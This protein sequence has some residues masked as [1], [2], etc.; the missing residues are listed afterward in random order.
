[1]GK[2]RTGSSPR[3]A[4]M[5]ALAGSAL[6]GPLRQRA[7]VTLFDATTLERGKRYAQ[8]GRI[9]LVGMDGDTLLTQCQGSSARPYAQHLGW[10]AH[11]QLHATCSCPVGYRCKHCL[12]ALWFL[13]ASLPEQAS[14]AVVADVLSPQLQQWLQRLPDSAQRRTGGENAR[15]HYQL[16]RPAKDGEPWSIALHKAQIRRDGSVVQVQPYQAL[17]QAITRLPRFLSPVDMRIARLSQ[18]MEALLEYSAHYTVR[19]DDRLWLK[20]KEGSELLALMLGT[21]HLFLDPDDSVQPLFGG[22]P[23]VAQF[24]WRPTEQAGLAP[25]WETGD[26][27]ALDIIS[28]LE[29]LWYLDPTSGQVGPVEH[30]LDPAIAT[31][32]SLAPAVPAAETALFGTLLQRMAPSLPAPPVPRQRL[33]EDVMPTA[34]LRLETVMTRIYDARRYRWQA[35]AR[36]VAT[37][38]F[39]YQGSSAWGRIGPQ[40]SV[41]RQLRGQEAVSIQRQPKAEQRLR[42][43]LTALG[44]DRLGKRDQPTPEHGEAYQ[45]PGDQAWI[46]FVHTG[47]DALRAAGWEIQSQP[48]FQ[49]DFSPVQGWQVNVETS[50]AG[51]AWFDLGLDIVVEG[52]Q[53]PLLPIVLALLRQ[54]PELLGLPDLPDTQ[55]LYVPVEGET[56]EHGRPLK[57]ALPYERIRPLLAMLV[58]F[59]SERDGTRLSLHRLDASQLDALEQLPWDW[60]GG[61]QLRDFGKRLRQSARSDVPVP[62]GLRTQLR[63]YQHDGLAWLQRLRELEVGGVLADDMGLGKTVQV[64]AHLLAEQQAGRRDRPSLIVM[65]TSLV[66]N[67]ED[68]AARFAPG[69]RVLTLHGPQRHQAFERLGEYDL[70][71]TTYALLPRDLETLRALPLHLLVLDEAQAIKN[72]ASKAAQAACQLQAR[73]RLCLSGTPLENHLGELWSLYHFL[74]PGWLG[75]RK[76]FARD[77]RT[78]IEQHGSATRLAHLNARL[79]PFLLRRNKQQVATQLP[80]KTQMVHWVELSPD[81]RDTYESVRTAMDKRVREE[82]KRHGLARSQIIILDALLKLRQVCCDL[83]LLPEGTRRKRTAS[84]SAKLEQLLSLLEELH[85]QGR[86]VLVFSQFTTMLGLI[87]QELQAR[88]LDYVKITGQTRDRRT[89]V[90]RFQS[91]Q[92][93]VFLISLKAGGTGLNLT[94]ADTV[95]HFDPWWNPAAENQ[96]TDR[97]H[98][99]GQDKPVFVY[100]LIARGTVEEKIQQLQQRKSAL[101]AGILESGKSDSWQW[102]EGDI[103]ALF[104]PLPPA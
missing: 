18:G 48:G 59:G 100:R 4:S 88:G 76:R 75:D 73:Q 58:F 39:D 97:A 102:D 17:Q 13:S 81:Q 52:R 7:W 43:Q 64:L 50:Q 92:V 46:D 71:L 87:E 68:E 29:P 42:R 62:T 99:I 55:L 34:R 19:L 35:Q 72:P 6:A 40:S 98:R 69:L 25:H 3:P 37:L 63:S 56:N 84:P 83:R 91:G 54:Q 85:E 26:G 79:Q 5:Q 101:A 30:A 94:A 38:T 23:R 8:Q 77:Y 11:G 51:Q 21:G 82:I 32:L 90:Q 49:F 65:P 61:D 70:L 44:F 45:L 53:M 95:I 47:A 93:P 86:R 15:L 28:G 67:W 74:M 2:Q 22:Q 20:G 96:A 33:L 14:T 12:A 103:Q 89:P 27:S 9:S 36:H 60:H 1:M 80:A 78:P 31:A 57:L 66:P 10:D 16:C 104:A 41:V 24:S